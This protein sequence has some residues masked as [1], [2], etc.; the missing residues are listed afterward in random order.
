MQNIFA[1]AD[2]K[3]NAAFIPPVKQLQQLTAWHHAYP[4]S[5]KSD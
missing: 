1:G 2:E 3:I 5:L 4:E